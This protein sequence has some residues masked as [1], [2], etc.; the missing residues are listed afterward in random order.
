LILSGALYRTPHQ[1]RK[2]Q[3][4]VKL[5]AMPQLA[6]RQKRFRHMESNIRHV[7]IRY[8]VERMG[9]RQFEN[10]RLG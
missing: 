5:R 3:T 4:G 10:M 2:R 8:G 1:S 6:A 7:Q 9:S